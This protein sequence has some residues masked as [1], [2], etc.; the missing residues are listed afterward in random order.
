[1]FYITYTIKHSSHKSVFV[2]L[3]FVLP[4]YVSRDK[5][6][7]GNFG[8]DAKNIE[9]HRDIVCRCCG[10][11]YTSLFSYS[12]LYCRCCKKKKILFLDSSSYSVVERFV[13]HKSFNDYKHYGIPD[14]RC[15]C[16]HR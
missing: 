7:G 15:H 14:V 1:M 4:N 10:D 3:N 12:F 2:H 11:S 16:K 6:S 13:D 5:F 8:R 9:K